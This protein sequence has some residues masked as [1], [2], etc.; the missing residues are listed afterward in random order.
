MD[1]TLGVA[2]RHAYHTK[3][4]SWLV[5]QQF[6]A[7]T[8]C[9]LRGGPWK[10]ARK[11][12]LRANV[13]FCAQLQYCLSSI[14]H[15]LIHFTYWICDLYIVSRTALLFTKKVAL[16]GPGFWGGCWLNGGHGLWHS[17]KMGDFFCFCHP[18]SSNHDL[19]VISCYIYLISR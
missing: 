8:L 11:D 6:E 18:L 16:K 19:S 4:V 7:T 9:R 5:S 15:K 13:R 10:S 12:R 17:K 2:P 1:G 14:F 3:I